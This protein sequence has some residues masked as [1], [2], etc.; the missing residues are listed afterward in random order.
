MD[1]DGLMGQNNQPT[2]EKKAGRFDA[3]KVK[4]R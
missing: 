2:S 3:N 1:F 4:G